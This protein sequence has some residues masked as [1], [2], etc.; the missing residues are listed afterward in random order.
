MEDQTEEVKNSMYMDT[1]NGPSK[2][3]WKGS[4]LDI[5]KTSMKSS[6]ISVRTESGAKNRRR[7]TDDVREFLKRGKTQEEML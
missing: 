4:S 5:S 7:G 2:Q 6:R 1:T 3:K